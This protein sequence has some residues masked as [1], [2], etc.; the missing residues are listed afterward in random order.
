MFEG[1]IRKDALKRILAE[2]TRNGSD[3]IFI[4]G[5]ASVK[6]LTG[7]PLSSMERCNGIYIDKNARVIAV[8]NELHRTIPFEGAECLYYQDTGDPIELLRKISFPGYFG[9]DPSWPSAFSLRLMKECRDLDVRIDR[10]MDRVRMIKTQ[11]EQSLMRTASRI[12]D[13]VMEASMKAVHLGIQEKELSR[14]I[15]SQFTIRSG[16]EGPDFAMAQFGINCANPH[17]ISCDDALKEGEACLLDI[18]KSVNGYWCD[19]TRTAFLGKASALQEEIYGIVL[20][21]NMAGI[22]ATAPGVPASEIDRAARDV[23]EKRGYGRYYT[24]RTG[25]NIG[26]EEHEWPDI[27]LSNPEPVQAGMCFSV[28]PGIYIPGKIGI[29]VED[30]V[31]VTESGVEV[32]NHADKKMLVL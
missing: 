3:Q 25:H 23:I 31:L 9:I 26:T 5:T 12:N 17:H 21:A 7:L 29:R 4:T 24:H 32:L 27:S 6:Y 19:M 14:F 20:E 11:E 1:R 16:Q 13:S 18:G 8:L 2:M 28:E 22:A 15:S 10:S 30:L